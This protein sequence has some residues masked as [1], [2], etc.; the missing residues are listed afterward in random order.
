MLFLQLGQARG[1]GLEFR[2]RGVDGRLL[3][4]EV[5]R[6]DEGLGNQLAGPA[7]ILRFAFLVGFEDARGRRYPA[8]GRDQVGVVLHGLRPIIHQALVDVVGVKQRRLAEGGKQVF[9]DSLDQG[10]GVSV[11]AEG[12]ELLGGVGAPAGGGS[13]QER[14]FYWVRGILR[15]EFDHGYIF[16]M[17]PALVKRRRVSR[18]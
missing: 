14:I 8:V 1:G 17:K 2:L 13:R 16:Q 9:G 10:L 11:L 7:L 3:F 18:T 6:D 5:A 12:R 4:G 15:R